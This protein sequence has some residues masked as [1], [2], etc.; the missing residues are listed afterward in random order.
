MR[1]RTNLDKVTGTRDPSSMPSGSSKPAPRRGSCTLPT[2]WSDRSRGYARGS[3]RCPGSTRSF[4]PQFVDHAYPAHTHDAWIVLTGDEVSTA[5]DETLGIWCLPS[6]FS[7]SQRREG[8]RKGVSPQGTPTALL[9]RRAAGSTQRGDKFSKD[10]RRHAV[11]NVGF[12]DQAHT[13]GT[14]SATSE[15]RAGG[16]AACGPEAISGDAS[17]RRH[18]RTVTS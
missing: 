3:P 13:L 14:S 7:P 2:S 5:Y 1:P 12:H 8:C 11:I 18:V 15:R 17:D 9:P 4:V 10:S 6:S 16:D